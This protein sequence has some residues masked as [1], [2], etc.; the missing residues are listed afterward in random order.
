M[1]DLLSSRSLTE[2]VKQLLLAKHSLVTNR[3][4]PRKRSVFR[5]KTHDTIEFSEGARLVK[6]VTSVFAVLPYLFSVS[7]FKGTALSARHREGET[8]LHRVVQRV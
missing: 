5:D 7:R 3:I 8:V 4:I 2:A 6:E 1:N